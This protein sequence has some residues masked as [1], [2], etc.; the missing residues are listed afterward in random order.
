MLGICRSKSGM[1]KDC[2]ITKSPGNKRTPQH[3]TEP[4]HTESCWAVV[5]NDVDSQ[6]DK[7]PEQNRARIG[8]YCR[9]NVASDVELIASWATLTTDNKSFNREV[10]SK[11]QSNG[12]NFAFTIIECEYIFAMWSLSSRYFFFPSVRNPIKNLCESMKENKSNVFVIVRFI[13]GG[14]ILNGIDNIYLIDWRL[15]QPSMY[16]VDFVPWDKS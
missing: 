5:R 11:S 13:G 10:Y 7:K 14:G 3:I 12:Q 4:N 2:K 16:D 15:I 6:M 9:D 1:R 8:C